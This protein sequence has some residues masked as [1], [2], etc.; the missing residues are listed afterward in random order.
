VGRQKEILV[1]MVHLG[2][3]ELHIPI[4]KVQTMIYDYFL[5]INSIF[6]TSSFRMKK[7]S[8]GVFIIVALHPVQDIALKQDL[9]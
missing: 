4:L 3:K 5:S 7:P 6:H 9:K 1:D 8:D 2:F